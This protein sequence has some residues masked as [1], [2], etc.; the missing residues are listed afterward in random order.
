MK[1]AV[2]VLT[3]LVVLLVAATAAVAMADPYVLSEPDSRVTANNTICASEKIA[4]NQAQ[5]DY[6][7]ALDRYQRAKAAEDRLLNP[8]T[9]AAR[10]NAE[11]QLLEA[12]ITLTNAKF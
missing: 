12:Q 2:K 10:R 1:L 7:N 3:P 9:T 4:V 5:G 8:A 6:N 11:Q